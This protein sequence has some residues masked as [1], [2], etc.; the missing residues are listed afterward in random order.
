M[1]AIP[2]L[3]LVELSE[4]VLLGEA[5]AVSAQLAVAG[6]HLDWA[7]VEWHPLAGGREYARSK[8]VAVKVDGIASIL[9]GEVTRGPGQPDEA[10]VTAL[11]LHPVSDDNSLWIE[12]MRSVLQR[13]FPSQRQGSGGIEIY[14]RGSIERSMLFPG[15]ESETARVYMHRRAVI[16]NM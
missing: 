4:L 12:E 15:S 16:R 13:D 7:R 1:S 5:Q 10:W 6:C 9:V 11:E 2:E 8:G 3:G 14:D